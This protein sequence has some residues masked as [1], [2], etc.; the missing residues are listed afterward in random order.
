[1]CNWVFRCGAGRDIL[2]RMGPRLLIVDVAALGAE[3]LSSCGVTTI[4]GLEVQAADTVFPAVTCTVQAS[5]RT[6]KGPDAHGM[7]STAYSIDA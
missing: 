6:G 4:A 7:I 1:V 3:L 5:L 2:L